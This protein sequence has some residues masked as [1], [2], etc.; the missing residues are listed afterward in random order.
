VALAPENTLLPMRCVT[1][2]SRRHPNSLESVFPD[3]LSHRDRFHFL[4]MHAVTL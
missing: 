1:R 4:W 2:P 3:L